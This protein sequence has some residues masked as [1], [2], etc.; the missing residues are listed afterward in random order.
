MKRLCVVL[1]MLMWVTV[2]V[3]GE[4]GGSIPERI[5]SDFVPSDYTRKETGMYEFLRHFETVLQ[6]NVDSEYRIF[7]DLK[8]L[9]VILDSDKK[10]EQVK[11]VDDAK[12]PVID[13]ARER[14]YRDV[15]S[16]FCFATDASWKLEGKLLLIFKKKVV[17]HRSCIEAHRAE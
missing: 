16:L 11:A 3:N 8:V 14:T 5:W 12:T 4:E 15:F 17:P 2:V 10:N 7:V 13:V 6:K 9:G 1:G